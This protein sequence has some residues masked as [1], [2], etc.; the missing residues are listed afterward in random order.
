MMRAE[1]TL[2]VLAYTLMCAIWGTTW[3]AIRLS[4][5]YVPPMTGVGVR[6]VLAG[7]IMFALASFT[8]IHE[9]PPW[10][11][12]IVLAITFFGLNYVLNYIA[13]THVSSGLTAVL[14]GTLPF[15][16]FLFAH[17]ML[18]TPATIRMWAGTALAF[19]GVVLISIVGGVSGSVW[20]MLCAVGAA[21]TAA[22]GNV[23]AKRHSH[24]APLATLPPA[25]LTAGLAVLIC[26]L[27][28][29]HPSFSRAVAP[30]SI[31]LL[32]YMAVGGSAVTF[33]INLWLLQRISASTVALSALIIPVIA[34]VV[35]IVLGGESFSARDL[36]GAA[37]VLAGISFALSE[38]RPL[39]TKQES[40]L[41][42]AKPT[43]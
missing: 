12:V 11:V 16:T 2:I 10:K 24:Y 29:E 22:F 43:A 15:F 26:G 31:G 21:C 20:Y 32:L 14:F 3:L 42:E 36:I 38:R 37:L 13:E 30:Q 9:R 6:F 1:R 18:D 35:G 4:L 39:L 8:R 33:F 7:A 28:F 40:A 34:V 19:A 17:R 5:H 27:A 23:Y 25:M 41:Q